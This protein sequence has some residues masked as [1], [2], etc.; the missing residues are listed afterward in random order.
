[1]QGSEIHSVTP[2]A[3]TS[4]AAVKSFRGYGTAVRDVGRGVFHLFYVERVRDIRSLEME[5]TGIG[6]FQASIIMLRTDLKRAPQPERSWSCEE[7]NFIR[8]FSCM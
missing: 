2:M 4:A 1:M 3:L 7:K 6:D 8:Q 5:R